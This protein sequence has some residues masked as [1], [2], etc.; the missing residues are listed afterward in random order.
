[1]ASES[2]EIADLDGLIDEAA[3]GKVKKKSVHTGSGDQFNAEDE[4][5]VIVARDGGVQYIASG[6]NSRL[7]VHSSMSCKPS[8]PQEP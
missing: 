6:T 3:A 5:T 2:P 8:S 7:T 1:M 4:A